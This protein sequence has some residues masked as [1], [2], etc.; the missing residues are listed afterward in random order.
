VCEE[1][2]IAKARQKNTN[3]V[4]KG[5]SK[6]SGARIYI[7]MSSIKGESFGGSKFWAL[8][9]D[10]YTDFC[11]RNFLKKKSDLKEKFV[12]F[13]QELITKKI[14]VKFVRY[15]NVSKSIRAYQ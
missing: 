11:W 15:N 5:G 8:I 1:C 2:A 13:I 10:V 7:D 6:T 4:A 3:K 12:N 9:V 14:D